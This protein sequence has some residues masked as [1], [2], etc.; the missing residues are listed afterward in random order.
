MGKRQGDH[1]LDEPVTYTKEINGTTQERTAH[2]NADKVN[3]RA[4]GWQP[5]EEGERAG[6]STRSGGRRSHAPRSAAAS[7]E[8]ADA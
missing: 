5:S 1:L 3:L 4:R 8:Q 7:S 6:S 2:T